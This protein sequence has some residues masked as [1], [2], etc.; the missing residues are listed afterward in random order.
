[1]QDRRVW[2]SMRR[3][4][5]AM[6][7]A[8]GTTI[9][10]VLAGPGAERLAAAAPV[11]VGSA[12]AV[13]ADPGPGYRRLPGHVLAEL[14]DPQWLRRHTVA[15][16]PTGAP[17]GP[18]LRLTVVLERD[19]PRAF[20]RYLRDVY[21]PG[22]RRYRHFLT[23]AQ[24]VERFGP[25]SADYRQ[26]LDYLRAQGFT[27]VRGSDNHLTLTVQGSEA[28]VDAALRITLHRYRVDG[29]TVRAADADPALPTTIAAHVQAIDGLADFATVHPALKYLINQCNSLNWG[30]R[31]RKALAKKRAA[32][33]DF[34][35]KLVGTGSDIAGTILGPVG[36]IAKLLVNMYDL[37]SSF[38]AYSSPQ[39][40]IPGDR[41][42]VASAPRRGPQSL[43]TGTGQVIGLLEFDGF[44]MSDVANYLAALGAPAAQ[45]NQVSVVPVNGGVASPGADEAE[46]LLDIDTVASIAP[47]AK[48]AVYEAPFTGQASAYATLFNAMING[49][50]T[51]IS[52]S[53][54]SCEDQVS[55]AEAQ[56]IDTVLQAAAA[57]GISVF[58]GTGDSG[59]VCEDG[60]ANTVA[61]PA[62]SPHATA[63]GGTSLPN[64]F[65]PGFT[66][67]G[68]TWWDGSQGAPPTGQ[69]GYGVSRYFAR[70]AY[71]DALNGGVAMRSVPDVAALA[72]PAEGMSLC[73][74][75]AGGCPT[76]S[77]IGGTSMATP[78]WAA[79]AALLNQLQGKNLGLL[80]AVVYPLAG[81]AAFHDASSMASD[82]AHVG[83]GSP[84]LSVMNELLN[85]QASGL[86]D[87]TQSVVTPLVQ[88]GT[89]VVSAAKTV[90][91]PADGTS[92]GGVLV[93]LID[94]N[95]NPVSGKTV[96]LTASGGSATIAGASAVTSVDNGSAAFVV[97][98]LTAETVTFTATDTTDAIAF[99]PVTLTFGVPSAA[100]GGISA[101]PPNV[102]AD[103]SSAAT[104]TVSLTDALNRPTPGKSVTLDA[105]TSHAVIS[106]PATGVTD[107]AGQASF[108]VTDQV[109]EAVTF[110]AVDLTDQGL[111]IPGTASV[112]YSGATGAACGVGV[113]PVAG[114]GYAITPYLTGLPAT[115]NLFYGNI[116]I[117]CIG[118]ESPVFPSTGG[119]LT[120]DF[121]TG[122]LYAT[123]LAGG[124]LTSTNLL[125]TLLPTLDGLTYGKDGS[126]YATDGSTGASILELDPKTGAI[127]RTVASGLTCPGALSVDPL[128]GDLFFDDA[129]TGAG[130]DNASIFRVIDPANTDPSRP[131]QVVVYATLPTTPNG[132]MAF[133]PNGDLYAVTGYYG[134]AHAAVEQISPTSAAS[135]SVTAV[136]GVSSDGPIAIGALNA[137]GSAQSLIVEPAAVL[138]E[139]P[140]A[141]PANATVMASVS[142]GVGVVGPDGCLYSARYD[143]IYRLTRSDGSC[144]F[145]PT[146][147]APA[148]R[149][150]QAG[151]SAS[152]AQGSTASF[153]V[154]LQNVAAPAGTEILFQVVGIN[155]QSQLAPAD[156]N[157]RAT[158][159]YTG[160]LGGNDDVY[161]TAT[162]GCVSLR[163]NDA[164]I[165]WGA[166]VD[167][168]SLSLDQ[169]PQSAAAGQ[170]VALR[171]TLF[172]AS[173]T[174][175]A[176]IAGRSVSFTLGG[177]SCSATTDASGTAACAIT[178]AGAGASALGASFSGDSQY[179]AAQ[180]TVGFL[181]VAPAAAPPTVSLTVS[182]TNVA[183]G[184]AATLTWSSTNAT[185]CTASGAW[186]GSE[187]VSGS[188]SVTPAINGSYTYT[189]SC[190]GAGGSASASAVLA[191]TLV[192]VTVT[193]HSGGGA[194]SPWLLVTLG[195]LVL[196]RFDCRGVRLVRVAVSAV[197]L[198]AVAF[199][200]GTARAAS[201]AGPYL[202]LRVG[203][204]PVAMDAG[205]IDR[206]L[207]A[208]GYG[209]VAAD[210][211]GSGLGETLYL[212]WQFEAR[213]ALELGYTHRDE[214][215]ADLSGTVP[216]TAA[217]A[218][219]LRD[220]TELLRGYGNIFSLSYRLR[221]ALRPRWAFEPRLGGYLWNTRVTAMT[222]AQRFSTNRRG[223]GVTVGAGLS[224][225]LWRG[226]R[227][228]LG[229]DYFRG[230][231]RNDAW[232]YGLS[233][234]WRLDRD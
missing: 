225:R 116:N 212:G 188:Q 104:V 149:L 130:T 128:S 111:P 172:D 170:S 65:G 79:F 220:A 2:A 165:A 101:N 118:A 28:A 154:T 208:L 140:L 133:A 78:E 73:Q 58:N 191:A 120:A 106:G 145:A 9:V 176:A 56:S 231:P 135:V 90:S 178:A 72:D 114:S 68:E 153:T 189:L 190:S 21:T 45:I 126:L 200:A 141:S 134:N 91:I 182:P 40:M 115:P 147:P 46:V 29:A 100:N 224:Y 152:P 184:S 230:F 35:T 175:P 97:T 151:G 180:T 205:G 202:G 183:A 85:G 88:P 80:N 137:D 62:D 166:G 96:T 193:A 233:V 37:I 82:F 227:L 171:A 8:L 36:A 15:S 41:R 211:H 209:T 71:Q 121:D 222:A 177:A 60:A 89:A 125:T 52:N 57:A 122:G 131:T 69:G 94:A 17:A 218:P 66:Y 107:A 43:P 6:F 77:L 138:T 195:L 38:A 124:T 67:A 143:T 33:I 142:P 51:V 229:A 4:G 157:G 219:L 228:G 93:T 26:V 162:A 64:G 217:V 201:D 14:R 53:W 215:A 61:V 102:A 16:R 158:F 3:V 213:D 132:G 99:A 207:A 194:M 54:A 148:L 146:N 167:V 13:G 187:P 27:L 161:A 84:N 232:L 32:C 44:H 86:P 83:L 185:A 12:R 31:N 70:P 206:G 1:M 39:S 216:D 19:H 110:S 155:A 204:M 75:D 24:L 181:S 226:L 203:S 47:G 197:A 214:H 174:P 103:G 20:A 192:A 234:E 50:V 63:V 198:T 7:A 10:L 49:G 123:S 81:T 23:Q 136:T 139:V 18:P 117:A 159:T 113:A 74:A 108:T 11:G 223:G 55:Q 129:C 95:G 221:L 119:V 112:T 30:I 87:P 163:S 59:N 168:A 210:T 186:S 105:G 34:Y 92:Q 156:A 76:N 98:D 25:S 196:L 109:N 160:V 127:L 48:V 5:S 199:S 173:L 164:N 22:N 42:L 150:T 144:G 179:S 169:S